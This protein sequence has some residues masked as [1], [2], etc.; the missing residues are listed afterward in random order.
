MVRL[1]GEPALKKTD[2]HAIVAL[3]AEPDEIAATPGHRW[4]ARARL[5]RH[6][7]VGDL[8]PRILHA[9]SLP[10]PDGGMAALRFWQQTGEPP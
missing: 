6:G 5:E 9:L 8:L 2:R 4:L 10:P 1:R 3:A 7:A